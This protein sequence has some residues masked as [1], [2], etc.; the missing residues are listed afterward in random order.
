MTLHQRCASIHRH[1]LRLFGPVGH[2]R[3]SGTEGLDSSFVTPGVCLPGAA[4]KPEILI[5]RGGTKDYTHSTDAQKKT[6]VKAEVLIQL[7]VHS[8]KSSQS[9]K[10]KSIPLRGISTGN[11]WSKLTEPHVTLI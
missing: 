7:Q 9:I 5:S 10:L 4:C 1:Q 3:K 2:G 11:F 8:L 6:L